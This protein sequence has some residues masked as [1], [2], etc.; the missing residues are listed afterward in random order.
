MAVIP[1]EGTIF[2]VAATSTTV[3]VA[4]VTSISLGAIEQD[5]IDTFA[6]DSVSKT[7]RP[8]KLP[9][10][11]SLSVELN[12]DPDDTQHKL[13]RDSASN[14]ADIFFAIEFS[15]GGDSVTGKGFVTSFEISGM[16]VDSNVTASAEI[17]INELTYVAGTES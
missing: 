16:E 4:G 10:Y 15:A 9:N 12:F 1:G 13:I 14:G 5:A 2:K 11:G 17:K 3:A 6:L 7:A 8:S